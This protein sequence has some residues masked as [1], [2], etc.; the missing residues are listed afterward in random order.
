MTAKVRE[1]HDAI[2]MEK[3][4]A[5]LARV[6]GRGALAIGDHV[7]RIAAETQEETAVWRRQ[8]LERIR[9]EREEL[10]ETAREQ[11]VASRLR[12]EQIKRVFDDI[13]ARL[14]IEE[15]RRVQAASDDR[16]LARRRWADARKTMTGDQQMKV[17]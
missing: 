5:R 12:K 13:A 2:G 11:Y 3:E 16:F 6:D 17:S 8:A 10:S 14:Q 7:E 4:A 1:A 15:G 9:K